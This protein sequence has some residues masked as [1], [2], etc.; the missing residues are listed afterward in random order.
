[1]GFELFDRKRG[2]AGAS[3]I[4][5]TKHGSFNFNK[6]AYDRYFKDYE[7]VLLYY[8]RERQVIGLKPTNEER[9]EA[10]EVHSR[11]GNTGNFSGVAF[12]R[13]FGLDIR[14]TKTMVATWNDADDLV[15][16]RFSEPASG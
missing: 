16:L 11:P 3:T 7:R 10:Y 15:E 12:I 14:E 4:A 13:H 9:R 1:M 5:L 2:P 6:A 8:D